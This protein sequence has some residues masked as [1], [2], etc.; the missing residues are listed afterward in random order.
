MHPRKLGP[1]PLVAMPV[2]LAALAGCQPL[3]G[4]ECTM[5]ID[6]SED[7]D[8]YC[9]RTQPN[10][11]CTIVD[12]EANACPSEAICVQFFDD[13]H[14]RSYCLRK[15]DKDSVC[16]SSYQCTEPIPGVSEVLDDPF[17]RKGYCAPRME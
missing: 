14:A 10:G 11:Y 7:G 12:C 17:E 2:L 8:R 6:C 5:N 4:D 13:V 9:D 15:C 1:A 16:R 3:I